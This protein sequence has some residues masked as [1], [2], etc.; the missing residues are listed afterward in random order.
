MKTFASS[1]L[2]YVKITKTQPFDARA[3]REFFYRMLI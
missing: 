2:F 1:L 3:E